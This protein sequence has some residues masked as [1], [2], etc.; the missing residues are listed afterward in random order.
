MTNAMYVAALRAL[1][2]F[3][4]AHPSLPGGFLD[5]VNI[6]VPAEDLPSVA[7]TLGTCEKKVDDAYFS[8]IKKVGACTVEFFNFRSKVCRQIVVGKKIIPETTIPAREAQIIPEHEEDDVRWEC[9]ESLL[10]QGQEL[11]T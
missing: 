3:F 8:L 11:N 5:Y 6:I 9:P 4:E 2:D 1:A 7:K 10:A